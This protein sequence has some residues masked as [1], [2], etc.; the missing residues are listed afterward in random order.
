MG[1][2][3]VAFP[4]IINPHFDMP[5]RMTGSGSFA[6]VE[7]DSEKDVMNCIEAIL[8]TQIGSRFY[9]PN[10]GIEDPTFEVQPIDT[11][12]IQQQILRNEPRAATTIKQ[13][14]DIVDKL[15]DHVQIVEIGVTE[16]E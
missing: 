16:R 5:F 3:M 13:S 4:G 14:L 12:G 7:Q 6:V 2:R 11:I 10:F 15:V 1:D 8:R 9:V